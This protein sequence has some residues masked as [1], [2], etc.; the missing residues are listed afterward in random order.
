M[1]RR[2][3]IEGVVFLPGYIEKQGKD[4]RYFIEKIITAKT[5]K[6]RGKFTYVLCRF[7]KIQCD[8]DFCVFAEMVKMVSNKKE[9]CFDEE[10]WALKE[11]ELKKKPIRTFSRFLV[12]P[13]DTIVLEDINPSLSRN[14]F[15]EMLKE[16]LDKAISKEEAV[17]Q[18]DINFKKSETELIKFIDS[19]DSIE[20]IR[21]YDLQAPNP[22]K[23]DDQNINDARDIIKRNKIKK[24][25]IENKEGLEY[26]EKEING[27]LGLVSG[28]AG[29]AVIDGK[30]HGRPARYETKKK[31]KTQQFEIS[32]DEEFIDAATS[33]EKED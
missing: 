22:Y 26:G 20:K 2:R 1:S 32:N 11:E 4:L 5:S 15:K 23:F 31:L 8:K 13:K 16:L 25:I 21:F 33:M 14:T 17:F 10:T 6:E 27:I 7:K 9:L 18:F 24:M 19:C 29:D 3:L 28:A 30:R 12:F